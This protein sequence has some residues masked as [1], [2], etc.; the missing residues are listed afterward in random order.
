MPQFIATESFLEEKKQQ[1][2]PVL[3]KTT[4]IT[5]LPLFGITHNLEV[6]EQ[7]ENN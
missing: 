5:A 6:S 4:V 7:P 1:T 2:A 3:A